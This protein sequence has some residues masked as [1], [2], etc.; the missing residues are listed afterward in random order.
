MLA[1]RP[2]M[3]Q[4]QKS[5]SQ[6]APW[7]SQDLSV[8]AS[9]RSEYHRNPSSI[10]SNYRGLGAHGDT[11]PG[12]GVAPSPI[13]VI[14]MQISSPIAAI[15]FEHHVELTAIEH[16]L[17]SQLHTAAIQQQ[18]WSRG[19]A[20]VDKFDD[21]LMTW[22]RKLDSPFG[23][24]TSEF[25]LE[26]YQSP[27]SI[28]LAI[29]FHCARVTTNMPA[30][31]QQ[32][33]STTTQASLVA[34]A[35]CV[36]SARQ[37]VEIVVSNKIN[38]ILCNNPQW[39]H[40]F[41]Q[42]KRILTVILSELGFRAV[43]MHS[44]AEELF[45]VAKRALQWMRQAARTSKLAKSIWSAMAPMLEEARRRFG[46]DDGADAFVDD[47]FEPSSWSRCSTVDSTRTFQASLPTNASHWARPMTDT[48]FEGCSD[49][50]AYHHKV[51]YPDS[52]D[53][54]SGDQDMYHNTARPET[55]DH[56]SSEPIASGWVGAPAFD[57]YY[58][59]AAVE[60]EIPF[61]QAHL[62]EYA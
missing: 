36:G 23:T 39:W 12:A 6:L 10:G 46:L 5:S 25:S 38:V 52:A 9:Q 17:V 27:L 44:E 35:R 60:D 42:L 43:Q 41:H 45:A 8:P 22:K 40:L 32:D 57:D 48:R 2:S 21:C 16:D 54:L 29:Q 30:L 1:G 19:Q 28:A 51:A 61:P 31:C 11:M 53:Q 50:P 24:T 55:F 7:D 47:N 33:H 14:S 56:F 4:D 37:V 34:V 3:G 15:Y 49:P 62:P 59:A 26:L 18:P 58:K 20:L 13:N